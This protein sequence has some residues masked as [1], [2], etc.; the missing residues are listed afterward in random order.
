MPPHHSGLGKA[1]LPVSVVPLF[2]H[3]LCNMLEDISDS[4]PYL[5]LVLDVLLTPDSD[6]ILCFPK[7]TLAFLGLAGD[8]GWAGFV[9]GS[10]TCLRGLGVHGWVRVWL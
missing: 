1:L 2:L 8:N 6:E 3:L 7:L 5:E 10:W 9:H 4:M